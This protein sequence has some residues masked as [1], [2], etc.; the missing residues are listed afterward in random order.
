MQNN[1]TYT[2]HVQGTK[3]GIYAKIDLTLAQSYL[4]LNL[5]YNLSHKDIKFQL[6][7]SNKNVISVC[8]SNDIQIHYYKGNS[9]KKFKHLNV[10]F[11]NI[12]LFKL[13]DTK[14]SNIIN[15]NLNLISS[16][17]KLNF[18]VEINSILFL[19]FFAFFCFLLIIN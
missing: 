3:D 4:L 5:Y 10:K 12:P 11:Q 7:D 19:F 2:Q 17:E 13:C 1:N 15:L 14:N 16:C 8:N 6:I 9:L 18:F